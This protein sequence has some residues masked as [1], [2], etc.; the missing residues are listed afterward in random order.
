MIKRHPITWQATSISPWL[1]AP[2]RAN[3]WL[4]RPPAQPVRGQVANHAGTGDSKAENHLVLAS[5]GAVQGFTLY[6]GRALVVK[7]KTTPAPATSK[8]EAT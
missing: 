7:A 6:V 1:L 4:P 5:A 8:P 3:H 2:G